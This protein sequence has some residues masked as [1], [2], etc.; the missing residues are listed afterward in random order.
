MAAR[1]LVSDHRR[2][3]GEIDDEEYESRQP[4]IFA[5]IPHGMVRPSTALQM[6]IHGP[7]GSRES[8]RVARGEFGGGL[9]S[10]LVRSNE[11][12]T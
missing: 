1:E 3:A 8:R 2:E 6:R 9:N 11:A 4:P 5:I 10:Q 7:P 12:G